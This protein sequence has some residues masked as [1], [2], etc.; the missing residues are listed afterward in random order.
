[1]RPAIVIAISVCIVALSVLGSVVAASTIFHTVPVSATATIL[2]LEDVDGDGCVGARDL[3]LV[4]RV[5]GAEAPVGADVN[6]D[7]E[8]DIVDLSLVAAAFG[9]LGSEPCP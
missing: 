5:L 3:F 8:M 9:T 4:A 2:P 1:M 7:G 6:R